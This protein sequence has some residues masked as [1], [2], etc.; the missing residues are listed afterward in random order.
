MAIQPISICRHAGHSRRSCT[1]ANLTSFC[2]KKRER[3]TSRRIKT[4]TA[5]HRRMR[6]NNN[7]QRPRQVGGEKLLNNIA[8]TKGYLSDY[9]PHLLPLFQSSPP[10]LTP[11]FSPFLTLSSSS[12]LTLSFSPQLSLSPSPSMFLSLYL[13]LSIFPFLTLISLFASYSISLSPSFSFSHSHSVSFSIS[14]FSMFRYF[15]I[16]LR[17]FLSLSHMSS[18]F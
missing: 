6:G 11:S 5:R 4:K 3:E 7:L 8:K 15:P 10:T 12:F 16:E 18:N 17:L 14:F 2:K 1:H 9:L 13:P